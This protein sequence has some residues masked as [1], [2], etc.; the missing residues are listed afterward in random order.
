[1]IFER[2]LNQVQTSSKAVNEM[3]YP[4]SALEWT[5]LLFITA[6][7]LRMVYWVLSPKRHN[8]VVEG[9]YSEKGGRIKQFI[10]LL[11]GLDASIILIAETSIVHYVVALLGVGALCFDLLLAVLIPNLPP[12]F[13]ADL[14]SKGKG[15][16]RLKLA[17]VVPALLLAAWTYYTIFFA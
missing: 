13:I 8:R 4:H 1:M 16:P 7:S 5:A 9:F 15:N 17:I 10:Y 6:F 11:I 14:Q 3:Q 12:N 2:R